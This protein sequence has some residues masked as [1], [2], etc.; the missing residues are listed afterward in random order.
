[1]PEMP[2]LGGTATILDLLDLPLNLSHFLLPTYVTCGKQIKGII[3][4]T[5]NDKMCKLPK[6]SS[7]VYNGIYSVCEAMLCLLN[8]KKSIT[9]LFE[10]LEEQGCVASVVSTF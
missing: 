7:T 4:H 8:T 6:Q 5:D 9:I 1:M 2:A 10:F 3:I